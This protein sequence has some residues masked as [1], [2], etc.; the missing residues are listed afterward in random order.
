MAQ[1]DVHPHPLKLLRN[2]LPYVVD[3][4]SDFLSVLETRVVVAL[5]RRPMLQPLPHL[6]FEIEISDQRLW[7]CP[8]QLLTIRRSSLAPAVINLAAHRPEILAALD[9]LITGI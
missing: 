2:E 7:F 8:P 4:Q 1:F 5:A 3:I 9:R 6:S